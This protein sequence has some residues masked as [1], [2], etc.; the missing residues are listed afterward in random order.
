M[1]PRRLLFVCHANIVRSPAAELLSQSRRDLTGEWDFASA[2]VRALV[3][4]PVDSHMAA[5]LQPYGID[6]TRRSGAQQ[7]SEPMVDASDLILTFERKHRER[8]IQ[9][10][11][12]A[13][14]RTLTIRRAERLLAGRPRRVE[15]LSLF[16]NDDRAYTEADDFA[17]PVGQGAAAAVEAAREI[18][19]LLNVILPALGAT[20]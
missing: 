4:H 6:A 16:G 20:R 11:P 14:R 1:T 10:S 9:H 19:R 15:V 18:A 5:A 7:L 8:V 3:G 2:G 17:D 12:A 13:A